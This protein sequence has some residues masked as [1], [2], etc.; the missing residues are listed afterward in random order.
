MK[1]KAKQAVVDWL[2]DLQEQTGTGWMDVISVGDV[3]CAIHVEMGRLVV[4][5][6]KVADGGGF[7]LGKTVAIFELKEAR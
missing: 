5:E 3:D 2:K 1:A 7:E 6:L 4:S